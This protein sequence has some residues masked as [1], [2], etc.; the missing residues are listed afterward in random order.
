MLALA[1][2]ALT[3]L[4]ESMSPAARSIRAFR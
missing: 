3:G 4:D 1:L 2:Y